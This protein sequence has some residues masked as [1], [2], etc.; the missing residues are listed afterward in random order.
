MGSGKRNAATGPEDV[1]A[2]G[3]ASQWGRAVSAVELVK[4][5]RTELGLT[6]WPTVK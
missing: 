2:E 6:P 5:A 1:I 4:S 3:S